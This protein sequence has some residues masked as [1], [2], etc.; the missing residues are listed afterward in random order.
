MIGGSKMFEHHKKESPILSLAGIGGGPSSY[1]F[2]SAS[3]DAN[4]V[5]EI[6]RSLRFNGE[7]SSNLPKLARN[8]TAGNQRTWTFSTWLKRGAT[9]SRDQVFS[10]AGSHNT[11][12]EFQSNKL[13]IEDY[14]SGVNFKVQ[15]RRHFI[16]SSAWYHIV[17]VVDTTVSSPASDRVRIYVNGKRETEFEGTPTYPT[18]NYDTSVNDTGE[19]K[20]GQFPGNTNFPFKGYLADVHLVDGTAIT[21]TNGVI[22]AFGFFDAYNV[23]QPK[24]YS[25]SHGN[26]G[27][28]LTFLDT[29]STAAIG[30]DS[31]G[32]NNYTPTNLVASGG[33]ANAID[34][35]GNDYIEFPGPGDGISGDFTMEAFFLMDSSS[36][37]FERIFSTNEGSY[38]D[39]QTIIRRHS[40]GN[41]QFYCGDSSPSDHEGPAITHSV[42]HHVAMVRSG[43]TV[44][45]YYDGSRLSTDTNTTSFDVTKLVVGGGI[46]SEQWTGDIHGARFT[47]GQALYSGATYTVPT[48]AITTTSQGAIASN[49][50]VLAGTTST[51]NENAGT[52]GNGTNN[53][54]PTATVANVFGD[55]K[56]LDV[57]HDSPSNLTADSGNNIGNYATLNPLRNNQTLSNGNLD[58]VG[59]SSWQRSC[60]T[61]SMGSGKWYWEYEIT[62]SNEHIV[63]VGPLDMQLSGNLGAGDPAGSGFNTEIGSVSGTGANGSWSNTGGLTTGALI[64]VAFDA[65]A[66]NMYIYVNGTALNSGTASHTGLTDGPYEAVFSLNGSSRSGSVNFGQRPFKYTPPTN[67]LPLCSKNLEATT[68]GVGSS[69][70]DIDL[71]DGTGS[72]LS[73]SNFSF[74]PEFLWFKQRSQD[75]TSHA[76][77]DVLRGGDKRL[78][79][80]E[81]NA[82]A[83]ISS[84]GGGVTSFDDDGF[85]LGTWS[86]INADTEN[87]VAWAWEAGGVPT[88]DN[89]AAAGQVPTAGSAKINGAN[90]TSSLAG[91]IQI[92]RLTA[93]TTTGLSIITFENPN[94]QETLGHGLGKKPEM[95]WVKSRD[96]GGNSNPWQ[97]YHKGIGNAKKL[98]WDVADAM[99]DTSVWGTTDPTSTLFTLN[100]NVNDSWVAYV[101]TGVEGFSSFGSYEG[102]SGALFVPCGFQPKWVMVKNAD[103]SNEEWII[104][105]TSRD[106]TNVAGHTLYA[107]SSTYEV[108]YRTG[109][110]ARS[111]SFLANGFQVHNGNPLLQSGTHIYAAFA[112]HPLAT[113]R[114]R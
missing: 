65:D 103:M 26:N 61:L 94:S 57:L 101:W 62:A 111:V 13:M 102:G 72:A 96:T 27:F 95:I 60:S 1:I 10:A 114:A 82:E 58:V 51:V 98:L 87:Y 66:G 70:F 48:S 53:G 109:G 76:L 104:L 86:T 15:L 105:D 108:D 107:D 89:V 46:G 78:Q 83:D 90:M 45:Y 32:S 6:S 12:I 2:Y 44:S 59:G 93:N 24:A 29:S 77:F 88:T 56:G 79:S 71:Y 54:D 43:N 19:H 5:K 36:G 22:D 67:Y 84:Y 69:L 74:S 113:A 11:Y 38:S 18:E 28:N 41:I 112:E 99:G 106:P 100:D 3:G 4:E 42:W 81:R 63:G 7:D 91:T 97:V 52:L 73:R 14:G 64:G 39:E 21:E 37:G 85:T 33:T 50:K 30:N 40:N 49:V 25:A 9:G 23:W 110:S 80:N 8:G 31:A 92:T 47:L 75:S 35:D 20:I 68:V 16:D 17:V 55:P 34:L